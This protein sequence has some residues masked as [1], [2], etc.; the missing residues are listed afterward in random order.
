MKYK[1]PE[2]LSMFRLFFALLRYEVK[3]VFV[4]LIGI[5]VSFLCKYLK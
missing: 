3:T 1:R 5:L 4:F 2:H